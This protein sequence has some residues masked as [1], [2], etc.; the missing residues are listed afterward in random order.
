MPGH[1]FKSINLVIILTYQRRK[2]VKCSRCPNFTRKLLKT[3]STNNASN[4]IKFPFTTKIFRGK[5]T[6]NN[7]R[8]LKNFSTLQFF[9][10]SQNGRNATER[11]QNHV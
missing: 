8:H 4:N 11:P 10:K 7:H 5:E 9:R 3:I 2:S 1:K 6:K